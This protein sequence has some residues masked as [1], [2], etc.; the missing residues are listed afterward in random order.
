[1]NIISIESFCWK[2]RIK[3]IIPTALFCS[4][5]HSQTQQSATEIEPE[6]HDRHDDDIKNED[7]DD[8]VQI[9]SSIEFQS[10]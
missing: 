6:N 10:L 8:D 1:M 7:D 4:K 9:V 5:G 2:Y 3:L